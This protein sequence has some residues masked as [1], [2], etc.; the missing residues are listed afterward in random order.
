MKNYER[1]FK[2]QN[3]TFK[4]LT[5]NTMGIK[6]LKKFLT[7]S[8]PDLVQQIHISSFSEKKISVDFSS[9]IYKY[10]VCQG[11][12]WLRSVFLFLCCLKKNNIHGVFVLD[13]IPP[14]EKKNEKEKRKKQHNDSEENMFLLSLDVEEYKQ[15]G[16]VSELLKE[17][18]QKIKPLSSSSEK[19]HR[20]LHPTKE[21]FNVELV[22]NYIAK[23]ESQLVNITKEDL[24]DIK[25]MVKMCGGTIVQAPGEAEAFGAYLCSLKICDAMISE[26]S[27]T[28]AYGTN[29]WISNLNVSSGI[30]TCIELSSV[31]S[32]IQ[33]SSSSFLDFCIMCG[34]DYNHNIPKVGPKNALKH[35]Y[36]CCSLEEIEKKMDTSILCYPVSRE[37]FLTFGRMKKV[38]LDISFWDSNVDVEAL[39]LFL[40][41]YGIFF[42]VQTLHD[43]FSPVLVFE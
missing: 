4:I 5:N 41:N 14:P 1:I 11:E 38:P 40:K 29:V 12:N 37:L 13:G 18:Y 24:E 27:D 3:K 16:T 23:K 28:L 31:L 33:L 7:S 15:S 34:T 30:C 21:E 20:L 9:Y 22:E 32:K 17:T 25:K 19:V 36:A 39:C 6:G 26:D 43:I 10:K 2:L 35:L 8:Y 42:S